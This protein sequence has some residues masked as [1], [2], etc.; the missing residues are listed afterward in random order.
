MDAAAEIQRLEGNHAE[1]LLHQ[2][3]LTTQL[4]TKKDQLKQI[5]TAL[6]DCRKVLS[7]QEAKETDNGDVIMK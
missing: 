2:E 5:R 3:T 6:A 7:A 4:Q 1:L